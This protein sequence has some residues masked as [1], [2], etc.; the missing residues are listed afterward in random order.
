MTMTEVDVRHLACPGAV[1]ELRKLLDAGEASIKLHV[2]NE[3]AKSNVTRFA[4][5]R[6][7][8]TSA[9]SRADGGFVVT[10]EAQGTTTQSPNADIPPVTCEM[11]AGLELDPLGA[12]PRV[13]QISSSRMGRGDDELGSLLM[14]SFLKAQLQLEARPNVIIFYN[15]GV[16]LCCKGSVVLD[17]LRDLE[18]SG[19]E[20]IACGTSLGLFQGA[21]EL[22]VGRIA[23]MLEIATRLATA[24]WLIRP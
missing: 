16:H 21:D 23:D 22:A 5:S 20:I 1:I 12:G 14:R 8:E 3:L 19:V 9:E 15:T 13:I 6:G 24:R 18:A 10:I 7:A 4:T 2:S 17:D 11:P